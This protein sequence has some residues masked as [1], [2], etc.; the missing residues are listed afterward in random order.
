MLWSQNPRAL[1][2]P[3]GTTALTSDLAAPWK[4][5]F[6]RLEPHEPSL[7]PLTQTHC[8]EHLGHCPS[9]HIPL[10][11]VLKTHGKEAEQREGPCQWTPVSGQQEKAKPCMWVGVGDGGKVH[12]SMFSFCIWSVR[13]HLQP[14]LLKPTGWAREPWHLARAAPAFCSV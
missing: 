11:M 1:L 5:L 9:L 4:A 12:E 6:V 13:L 3:G 8:G 2:P 14:F 10:V 7:F